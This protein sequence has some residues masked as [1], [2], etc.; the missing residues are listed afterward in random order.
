MT[1]ARLRVSDHALVRWLQRTGAF[2]VERVRGEL[3]ASLERSLAAANTLGATRCL[4]V[5]D[6]LTYVVR[7]G[8]VVT[9][10]EDGGVYERARL[11]AV[12][13]DT[14]RTPR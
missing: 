1:A 5:A 7:H 11:L 14:D 4:I 6:G 3:A 12:G 9:V 8:A 2:D 10:I 13:R